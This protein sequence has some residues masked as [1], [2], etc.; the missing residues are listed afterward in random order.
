M[1]LGSFCNLL[2]FSAMKQWLLFT[3]FLFLIPFQDIK[4][5]KRPK[6][7]TYK[8]GTTNT[9]LDAQIKDAPEAEKEYMYLYLMKSK[10]KLL[11]N[12]CVTEFTEDMGFRYILMPKAGSGMSGFEQR[13]NNFK[14]RFILL[15]RNGPFWNYRLQRKIKECRRKTGDYVG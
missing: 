4:A 5:Q 7:D 15:F 13:L 10:G 11:G 8:K 3:L 1:P 12:R 2:Y 6:G 9:N 14:T